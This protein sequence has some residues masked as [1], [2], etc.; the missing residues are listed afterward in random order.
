MYNCVFFFGKVWSDSVV[1][2]LVV[3]MF[4]FLWIEYIG[5][6]WCFGGSD[7]LLVGSVG[8][9]D[10][11]VYFIVYVVFFRFFIIGLV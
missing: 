1:Q 2:L 7:G 10:Y 11:Y 9:C 4:N 6:I 8:E 5:R 3:C